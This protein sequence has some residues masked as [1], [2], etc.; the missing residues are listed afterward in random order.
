MF[1]NRVDPLGLISAIAPKLSASLLTEALFVVQRISDITAQDR[2][3]LALGTQFIAQRQSSDALR[4]S[5]RIRGTYRDDSLES[6]AGA[7]I[8]QG[9]VDSALQLFALA[10]DGGVASRI[11]SECLRASRGAVFDIAFELVKTR[12][13]PKESVLVVVAQNWPEARAAEVSQLLALAANSLTG[14]AMIQGLPDPVLRCAVFPPDSGIPA[15][16][17]RVWVESLARVFTTSEGPDRTRAAALL[18]DAFHEGAYSE[19]ALEA[20]ARSPAA[21]EVEEIAQLLVSEI[22][23]QKADFIKLISRTIP[24]TYWHIAWKAACG[25][26]STS[27]RA[28]VKARLAGRAP[29]LERFEARS[30]VLEDAQILVPISQRAQVFL[31]VAAELEEPHRSLALDEVNQILPDL[32]EQSQSG[33][34]L[35]ALSKRIGESK[36]RELLGEIG[37][38][39]L[40]PVRGPLKARLA[41]LENIKSTWERALELASLCPFIQNTAEKQKAL[42]IARGMDEPSARRT[43]SKR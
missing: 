31:E 21:W 14:C 24:E 2:A 1:Q 9:D 11:L 8:R 3:W 18:V 32:L 16:G 23:G 27:E 22:P 39:S 17:H 20:L 30:S 10:M 19:A 35:A 36:P 41:S 12:G 40:L 25:I 4:I 5:S 38:A 28:R 37:Y 7:F 33:E 43:H 15:F 29:E 6:L 34:W 13:N 26:T 42:E